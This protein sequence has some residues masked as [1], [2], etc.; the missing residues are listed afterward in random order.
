MTKVAEIYK[1]D[2]CDTIVEVVV[3]GVGELV[4][5]N[6]PMKLL[7]EK[8]EE[9]LFE[10]HK[11]VIEKNGEMTKIKVGSLPHPMED[12]HYI[13]FIE[14]LAPDKKYIKR[15]HLHPHEVPEL[16]FKCQCDEFIAREYCNIHGFF[17]TDYKE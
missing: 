2:V 8:T 16:E 15:K 12:S 4:C 5:C 10:K 11:P 14:A 6:K 13:M 3:S 9:T 17:T 1:C 7:E